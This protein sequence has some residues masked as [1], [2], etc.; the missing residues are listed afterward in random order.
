MARKTAPLGGAVFG[1]SGRDGI[2]CGTG[3]INSGNG[4]ISGAG[5]F[6]SRGGTGSSTASRG[7]RFVFRIA[8]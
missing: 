2:N 3:V 5:A 4:G 8:A 1:G 6:G 7:V